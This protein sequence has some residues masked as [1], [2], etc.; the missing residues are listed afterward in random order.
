M[1]E[2]ALDSPGVARAFLRICGSSPGRQQVV[3]A[4]GLG[5][6]RVVCIAPSLS[7]DLVALQHLVEARGARFH[8]IANHRALVGLVTAADEV[9][10]FADGLLISEDVAANALA[11]MPGVIVQPIEQ[12][13][14]AGFERIDLDTAAA[15]ALRI[16]GRLVAQLNDL[17]ADCDAFS[18]LQRIALQAGISARNLTPTQGQGLFWTLVTSDAQAQ[19]IEPRLIRARLGTEASF[20]TPGRW[21]ATRIV[22]VFGAALLDAGSGRAAIL[23]GSVALSLLACFAG[24]Y[25]LAAL[26][27]GLAGSAWLVLTV[28]ML[29]VRVGA[30]E[31][32]AHDRIPQLD[33]A[34]AWLIDAA[35]VWLVGW[36]AVNIAN[37]PVYERYFPALMLFLMLHLVASIAPPRLAAWLEDRLLLTIGLATAVVTGFGSV[38]VY[39]GAVLVATIGLVVARGF[40]R[41]T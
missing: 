1:V 21:L 18:T 31:G 11:A 22:E 17:P 20:V 33:L 39:A 4:L 12:G 2:R 35:L 24:A 34:L 23:G 3:A 25:G 37:Q 40:K 10:A 6:E 38:F 5:C 29:L 41:I 26:G 16:P 13:L 19:E 14:P 32:A 27:I 28:H 15:G 9:I 36:T 8:I 7:P 30:D